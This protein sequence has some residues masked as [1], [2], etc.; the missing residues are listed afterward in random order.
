MGGVIKNMKSRRAFTLVE[1]LV[2]IAIIAILAALLLPVLSQ[3]KEKAWR[4]QCV[5]NFKQLAL[6]IQM[7]ADDHGDQLPGPVW[8]GSYEEYDN[9]DF[10]RLPYYIAQYIGLPAP[11]QTP[12]DSLQSRCPSAAR[13]WTAVDPGTSLMSMYV[14]LS[15]MAGRQITNI[16]SGVV[17]RP[18]G[19]PYSLPPFD[20]GTNEAPKRMHEICS[21]ALSW[22]LTDV[23]QD[24]G[25]YAA[26]YYKFLPLTPAHGSV[27]NQLFFDWHVTAVPSD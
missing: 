13:H 17:T 20:N 27:R 25:I 12:Q 1:L 22:A 11:Q 3:A 21:P 18:F 15:Y 5:N 9:Q 6:A 2:V 26:Q 24:N 14:P 7:Y 10:P 23:D 8:L 4:T 19:Y 16:N